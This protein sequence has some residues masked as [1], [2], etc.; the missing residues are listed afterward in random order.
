MVTHDRVRWAELADETADRIRVVFL[1]GLDE[2]LQASD[3]D[4]TGYLHDVV[5]FQ[6]LKRLGLGPS[7]WVVSG[8]VT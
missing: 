4:L 3:R 1:D 8:V 2:L 7:R 5:R 6:D